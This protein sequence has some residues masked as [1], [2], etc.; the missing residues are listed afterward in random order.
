MYLSGFIQRHEIGRRI[1]RKERCGCTN[2]TGGKVVPYKKTVESYMNEHSRKATGGKN[3][4][5]DAQI[6]VE[7]A[8]GGSQKPGRQCS[9]T[10]I[11]T[12]RTMEARSKT[13]RVWIGKP[14]QRAYTER[15]TSICG[16]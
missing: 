1:V 11:T 10:E 9:H 14:D 3:L 5:Q 12:D 16:E 7:P 13:S 6:E 4:S 8:R 2:E 15:D